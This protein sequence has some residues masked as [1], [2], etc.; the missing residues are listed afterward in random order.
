MVFATDFDPI[1]ARSKSPSRRNNSEAQISPLHQTNHLIAQATQAQQVAR[2]AAQMPQTPPQTPPQ[3]PQM[4]RYLD[5]EITV[6]S[7]VTSSASDS[8]TPAVF[9]RSVSSLGKPKLP[10]GLK[11][12]NRIQH[13][14]TVV[15]S[16]LIT[17]ALVLYGSSVYVDRSA[18]RT[19]SELNR[20]QSDS[21]QLTAANEAIKQS[22]AEQ[23]MSEGSGLEPYEAGDVLFV[24]PQPMRA[25]KEGA[26]SKKAERLRPLGY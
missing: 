11:L 14:S 9:S 8:I 5:D 20:L 23:A 16:V 10:F 18:N 21:Q 25:E 2:K 4:T 15:T 19:M 13:G 24:S 7:R 17:G 26:K 1:D 3:M 22:M 12:L 6:A